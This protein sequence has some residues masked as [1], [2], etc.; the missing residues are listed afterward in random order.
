M[1]C[2]APGRETPWYAVQPGIEPRL[3]SRLDRG[4]VALPT[5]LQQV[6]Y[7]NSADVN[8]YDAVTHD[9]SQERAGVITR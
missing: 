4:V 7:L 6:Y 3:L 5:A 2:G 8:T 1:F 9:L